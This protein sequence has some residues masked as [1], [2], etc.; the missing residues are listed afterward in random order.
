[1]DSRYVTVTRE[2]GTPR[3]SPWKKVSP[4]E[5]VTQGQAYRIGR[6]YAGKKYWGVWSYDLWESNVGDNDGLG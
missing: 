6:R 5:N 3:A 1:M 4:G 2:Y